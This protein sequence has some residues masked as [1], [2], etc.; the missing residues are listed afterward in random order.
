VTDIDTDLLRG[1]PL[2]SQLNDDE[3]KQLAAMLVPRALQAN[4]PLF[5]TGEPGDEMYV[6]QRG[7]IRLSYP[8]D[9]GADITLAILTAGAFFGEISMLD[10]GVRTATAR[11]HSD[12]LL[13]GLKRQ[14]FHKFIEQH[15]RTAVPIITT[16]SA[17]QREAMDKLRGVRNVNLVVQDKQTPL[18]R[19]ID[20]AANLFSSGRFVVFQICF[21]A[22]WMIGQTIYTWRVRPESIYF[23]DSPPTFFWLCLLIGI[24]SIM[25]TIFVLNS[26]R[27]SAD[28]DRVRADMEYQINLKAQHDVTLL[29]QKIDKLQSILLN[30]LNTSSSPSGSTPSP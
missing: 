24:E 2:F 16:L 10:G 29:H 21:I 5:W 8:D 4:E 27:R 26:Q 28:R 7:S 9:S 18:Q 13:L 20:A 1:I 6:V 14:G 11:G 15:P 23:Y 30:N 22:L 17:R 12:A 25:L 19:M 3:R